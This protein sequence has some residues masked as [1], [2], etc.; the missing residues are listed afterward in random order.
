MNFGRMNLFPSRLFCFNIIDQLQNLINYQNK[1]FKQKNFV[2]YFPQIKEI[3]RSWRV[4]FC[5]FKFLS[6][7]EKYLPAKQQQN[8]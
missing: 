2:F 6:F 3:L 7:V 4:I 1:N 5:A 8:I